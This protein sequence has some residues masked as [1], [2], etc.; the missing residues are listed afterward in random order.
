MPVKRKAKRSEPVAKRKRV[1]SHD[2]TKQS[3]PDRVS[4]LPPELLDNVLYRLG[5]SALAAVGIQS[6]CLYDLAMPFLWASI[7]L[8]DCEGPSDVG[9]A[10]SHDDTPM[11]NILIT[12]AQ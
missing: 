9:L 4:T 7:T 11:V 1:A 10:A 6:R 3:P 12:L 8:K 2:G 5:N